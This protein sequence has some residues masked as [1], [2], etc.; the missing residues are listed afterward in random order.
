MY[1]IIRASYGIII[2]SYLVNAVVII[3]L[4]HLLSKNY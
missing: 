1:F 2:N 3:N 4:N